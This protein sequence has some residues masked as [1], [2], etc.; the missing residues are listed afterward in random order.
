MTIETERAAALAALATLLGAD[1]FTVGENPNTAYRREVRAGLIMVLLELKAVTRLLLK[2]GGFS[3]L[4]LVQEIN[5]ELARGPVTLKAE[6]DGSGYG[7][8][9]PINN[10]L[11][12]AV[13]PIPVDVGGYGLVVQPDG[14]TLWGVL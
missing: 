13:G 14:S 2:R 4:Q 9:G 10:Q 12:R 11:F 5:A 3:E 1:D 8:V 6:L 7:V